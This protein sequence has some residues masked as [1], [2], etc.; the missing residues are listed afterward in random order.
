MSRILFAWEL[1]ANLGHLARDLPVAEA[2]RAEGHEIAFAVRDTRTAA[3]LLTPKGFAFTQS[4]LCVNRTRLAE[5]PANY[6]EMLAAEGWCDKDALLGHL[7]AWMSVI[8]LG[9]FDAVVADHAPGALVA[10]HI[11]ERPAISFGSGFEIP[12]D[13]EPMPGIRPWENHS[14][15]RLL[16]SE[17]KVLGHINAAVAACGGKLYERLGCMFAANAV[18]ASFPELDHYGARG[19]GQYV[20]SIHGLDG[21][22]TLSWPATDGPRVLAYLRPQHPTVSR[23]MNALGASG[24]NAICVVPGA[25]REFVNCYQRDSLVIADRPVALGQLLKTADVVVCH[26]GIGTLAEALL[27]GVPLLMIPGTVEQYLAA[28]CVESLGAGMV[29]GDQRDGDAFRH[30]VLDAGERGRLATAARRFAGNH[31][32]REPQLAARRAATYVIDLL[33]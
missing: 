22:V 1:G 27:A 17:R 19:G 20:G 33:P 11:L 9:C 28:R 31:L 21:A 6:A 13:V 16:S 32:H 15:G 10:A 26:A 24:A 23:V 25:G 7:Q 8:R 3:Q 5:P 12:P 2:L 4:P 29:V 30:A 14:T 18:L